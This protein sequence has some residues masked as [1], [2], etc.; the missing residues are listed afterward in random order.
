MKVPAQVA[1]AV[2]FVAL[3]G[4]LAATFGLSALAGLQLAIRTREVPTPDV[5]GQTVEEATSQ[6]AAAGLTARLQP[7][8]R[9]HATIDAGQVAEQDPSPGATTRSRR[10]VKLWLS[11]GPTAGEVP[12]VIGESE[13]GARRRLLD[14]DVVIESVAEIRSGRYATGAVVA[15]EPPPSGSGDAVSLL[16]N[17]GE[18]GQ[19]Y[20]MPDLI[21]VGSDSAA[22]ILRTRGFRVSVVADHPYP[23]V[24]SGVILRQAPAA[25]F[26]IAPGEAISLEVSR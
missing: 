19:T 12:P 15:Q 14:N 9:I 23:G 26:Q 11:S 22:D 8:R 25:G 5:T 7:L 2:R 1:R 24:P 18:R 4:A 3:T 13:S 21:G 20:V 17:R 6:L 16:V 10:S